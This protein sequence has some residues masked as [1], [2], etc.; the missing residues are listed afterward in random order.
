MPQWS[1]GYNT[2]INYIKSTFSDLSPSAIN[3]SLALSSQPTVNMSKP[4]T[5]AE[6]GSGFGLSIA[7]WAAQYPQGQFFSID[8]NPSQTA[9]TQKLADAAG[10]NNLKIYE[11][12]F[13]QILSEDLPLL[14]FVVMHGVYS[15]VVPEVRKNIR[16]F[17]IK[18]LKPGGIVYLGY[19]A[20]PG[21]T[22]TG[23]LRQI[24][25]DGAKATG[26]QNPMLATVKGLNF[27]KEL[28]DAGALYFKATGEGASHWLQKWRQSPLDYL[29]NELFNKEE[30]PFYFSQ[31]IEDMAEA[32]TS[33]VGSLDL[34]NYL[35]PLITPPEFLKRINQV[36]NNLALREVT[37]DF[38]Y[39]TT[40]RKDLFVKG[41]QPLDRAQAEQNLQK[42]R[43]I[44]PGT[45][46]SLPEKV[47]LRGAEVGLKPEIYNPILDILD[48][49]GPVSVAN[50]ME[51]TGFGLALTVQAA[52]VI[53]SLGWAQV[54]PP[55]LPARERIKAFNIALD[56]TLGSEI[57]NNVLASN[58]AWVTFGP[59]E[60]LYMLA[61]LQGKTSPETFVADTFISRGWQLNKDKQK[62]NDEEEV[63]R[64]ILEQCQAFSEKALIII[65]RIGLA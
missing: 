57:N 47:R 35:E 41:A 52:T 59:L 34:T 10:L 44:A 53:L 15:W 9:W 46:F 65:Q 60:R 19:N 63:R 37:K 12:S 49:S 3:F 4:F 31:I 43:L 39:N 14:D 51:K 56:E 26:E 22:L 17:L 16:D 61:V 33:Y 29:V 64:I 54:S 42:M 24:I 27:L 38:L 7:G 1:Q 21:W 50:I 20:Q 2:E 58:G 36:G 18:F 23:P 30:T 13:Q 6:L 28:E 8:F 25:L 62:L 11:Q 48:Q 40:F 55:V 5:Y 45:R 32:K